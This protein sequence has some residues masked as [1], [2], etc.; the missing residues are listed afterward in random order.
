MM[1]SLR[2]MSISSSGTLM[3]WNGLPVPLDMIHCGVPED[4]IFGGAEIAS[5][6]GDLWNGLW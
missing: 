5:I 1:I 3:F 4:M 6:L 2:D